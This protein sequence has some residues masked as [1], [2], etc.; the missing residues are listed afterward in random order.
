MTHRRQTLDAGPP[1]AAVA[2][3]GGGLSGLYA[4]R[5]LTRAHVDFV[6]FEAQERLGGRVLSQTLRRGGDRFGAYDLGPTWFWP[7]LQPRLLRLIEASRLSAFAQPAHGDLIVEHAGGSL[8]RLAYGNTMEGAARIVGGMERLVSTLAVDLEASR[9]MLN[10]RVT[11]VMLSEHA[12]ALHGNDG[13]GRVWKHTAPCIISTLP[14]RLLA[15][16]VTFL[17]S[18]PAALLRTAAAIPTW[19]AGHAKFVA[20]YERAFW[21]DQGLS[22]QAQS[23]V[24]PLGEIHDASPPDGH[25]ALFGF[26][27]VPAHL[28]RRTEADWPLRALAQL[29]RLFGA[30]AATP[31]ATFYKDWASDA[32]V[33]TERD[34]LAAES[35]PQYGTLTELPAPW[36]ERFILAG[37]ETAAD[38]GGFLEGALASAESA[39]ASVLTQCGPS[40]QTAAPRD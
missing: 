33:S 40:Q 24:G 7:A 27:T 34:R 25:P 1:K 8:R 18:L 2:I 26:V 30:P 16:A 20:V 3:V 29:T 31:L 14:P 11:E 4:A 12:V 13:R 28:R 22:G 5:L 10:H 19:M 38:A 21:R 17:P 35:H 15:E 9:I 37:T 23:A 36:R 39:V 32:F 6:L